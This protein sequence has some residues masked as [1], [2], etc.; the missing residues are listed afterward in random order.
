M[1]EGQ[2]LAV[3]HRLG[4]AEGDEVT[5][6]PVL[7]VDG[8]VV[9]SR[10]DEL[11]TPPRFR[12]AGDRRQL[13]GPK[14]NGFTYK[15]KTRPGGGGVTASSTPPIEITGIEPGGRR[16]MSK[17]KGGGST[18]NGRDSNAQRLGVK[19]FDGTTVPSR[20]DNR[21]PAGYA[22]PSRRERRQGQRRHPVRASRAA[23]SSS[24]P[25]RAMPA[26][27]H[28]DGGLRAGSRSR[29]RCRSGEARSR[30]L[31]SSTKLKSTSRRV[32]AAQGPSRFAGR[33]T[34]PKAGPTAA[35]AAMAAA[36]GW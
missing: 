22:L 34:W 13:E 29:S 11:A 8:E 27:R 20:F 24:V 18:R 9:L 3:E 7:V 21:A 4:A 14:V 12:L 5:L 19:V 16:D 6:E 10:C 28:L 25:G 2:T 17:T 1:E 36:S 26:G 30:C 23:R 31:H 35:T 33:P 15:P 32:T